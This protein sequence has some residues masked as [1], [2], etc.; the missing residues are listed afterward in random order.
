MQ[1]GEKDSIPRLY[2]TLSIGQQRLK[3]SV[4]S[5]NTA[6]TSESRV[7]PALPPFMMF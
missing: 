5:M 6:L 7:S 3:V 2:Y 4:S 1:I